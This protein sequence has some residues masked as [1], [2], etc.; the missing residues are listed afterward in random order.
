MNKS[1]RNRIKQVIAQLET[2]TND[3]EAVRDEEDETRENTPENLQGGEAYCESEASSDRI[4]DAL[5][6]IQSAVSTLEE[7]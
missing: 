4:E 7:I 6:D 1:R 2:C 3:L 5:S